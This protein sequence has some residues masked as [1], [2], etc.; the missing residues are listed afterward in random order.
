[1][2][3]SPERTEPFQLFADH[4]ALDFVNTLDERHAPKGPVELLSSYE[5]LLVFCEQAGLLN[6]LEARRL[7]R[8]AGESNTPAVLARAKELREALFGIFTAASQGAPP[9]EAALDTLNDMLVETHHARVIAW[10]PPRYVWQCEG[11]DLEPTTPLGRIAE[12]AA[13]LLTSADVGFIKECGSATCRWLFLDRTR[14][15]SRRWCDMKTCGNRTKARRF[16]EREK[17]AGR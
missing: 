17:E 9:P 12:A 5:R 13:A 10:E 16:H 8:S 3:I 2:S 7:K 14:N 4:V 15:H 6:S 11:A 1:V